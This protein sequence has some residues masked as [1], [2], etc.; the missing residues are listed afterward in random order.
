MEIGAGLT[1]AGEREWVNFSRHVEWSESF[2]L[3]FL[4]C[5][6]TPLYDAFLTQLD[7]LYISRHTPMEKLR[8][9]RHTTATEEIL[10]WIRVCQDDDTTCRMPV[11]LDLSV[12]YDADWDKDRDNLIARLNEHRELLRQKLHRPLI[13]VL[14]LNYKIRLRE[15][16]PDLWA[17]RG[18]S[19][20]LN[21]VL[22]LRSAEFDLKISQLLSHLP[23]SM[24]LDS[25]NSLIKEAGYELPAIAEWVRL[26]VKE[27]TTVGDAFRAGWSAFKEAI[28]HSLLE[29]AD[30]IVQT[31]FEQ[32]SGEYFGQPPYE[33]A[34]NNLDTF[35]ED[36][37]DLY[38]EL[39]ITE[40]AREWSIKSFRYSAANDFLIW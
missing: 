24:A 23:N 28:D 9:K 15:I 39:G 40:K 38:E 31:V 19:L 12:E 21:P 11:W 17:V 3:F 30:S 18:Y 20:E 5:S 8:L 2:A 26:Q 32:A 37:I 16:A 29:A 10:T 27:V 14:P 34:M 13:I 7:R 1:D 22:H 6:N 33:N 4:F 36:V 35:L 25:I